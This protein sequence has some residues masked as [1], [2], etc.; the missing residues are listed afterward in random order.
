MSGCSF[1]E[2]GEGSWQRLT[3]IYVTDDWDKRQYL[4]LS[5]G[6]TKVYVSEVIYEL[7]SPRNECTRPWPVGLDA[8]NGTSS[9]HLSWH[10][11]EMNLLKNHV[12]I[13]L[14]R[15]IDCLQSFQLY[16]I[17]LQLGSSIDLSRWFGISFFIFVEG[18]QCLFSIFG[19]PCYSHLI[20]VFAQNKHGCYY[21]KL[22]EHNNSQ[23]NCIRQNNVLS[24]GKKSNQILLFLMEITQHFF[25]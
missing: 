14:F 15:E 4:G 16:Q 10:V 18:A 2:A 20:F 21:L 7:G 24:F 3:L 23:N 9:Y 25:Y 22:K 6:G 1:E 12:H 11:E 5:K 13:T 19:F 8:D 17:L